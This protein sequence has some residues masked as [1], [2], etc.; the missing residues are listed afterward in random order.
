MADGTVLWLAAGL[1]EVPDHD[2]WVDPD[3]ADRFGRMRFAKRYSE[4]RLARWTAKQAIAAARGLPDTPESLRSIVIRNAPD[5]APEAYVEEAPVGAVIAMTD[6]ADWSV[7]AII[8]SGGRVGCDLELVEPRSAAFVA[9]YFTDTEQQRIAAAADTRILANVM[10]SAKESA[11]KVLRTGLRRD[12][13]TVE[14]HL[15][16]DD[17][18]DWRPLQVRAAE[19]RSFPGW[20]IRFGEF[21]LTIATEEPTSAPVSLVDPPGLAGASPAHRWMEAMEV[22]DGGL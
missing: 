6:R 5:G 9:D 10:W 11:L 17:A 19:G 2:E 15:D 21:L 18:A 14:V 7:C 13:R 22:P 4:A 12:T 20:W 1:A 3:M 16:D 8:E